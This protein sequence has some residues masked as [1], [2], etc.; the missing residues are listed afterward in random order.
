MKFGHG[1]VQVVLSLI[2]DLIGHE[3]SVDNSVCIVQNLEQRLGELGIQSL[4]DYFR[5]LDQNPKE[6]EKFISLS[7]VH[8]TSWFRDH[9]QLSSLEA[10]VVSE[11]QS[12]RKT[13]RVW[14]AACSTGQ[15]IYSFALILEDLKARGYNFEY[16]LMGSDIDRLSL[17]FASAA[18]YPIKQI[19]DIPKKYLSHLEQGDSVKGPIFRPAKKILDRA[20]FLQANLLGELSSLGDF[21]LVLLRNIL[22]YF[23][24]SNQKRVIRAVESRVSEK[25]LM[26]LG[27]SDLSDH[28]HFTLKSL[29]KAF[30]VREKKASRQVLV[31]DD[32]AM[33][34]VK[35]RGIF[36]TAGFGV[37]V[38]STTAE[39]E[40]KLRAQDFCAIT[41]DVNLGEENGLDWLAEK[42]KDEPLLV[43]KPVVIVSDLSKDQLDDEYDVIISETASYFEKSQLRT[44]SADLVSII[45]ELS[46]KSE[47]RPGKRSPQRAQS[48][49]AKKL[50]NTCSLILIGASTGG[51]KAVTELLESM[52]SN[53]PPIVIVQH[54][55][56]QFQESFRGRL[57]ARSG[58]AS[59]SQARERLLVPGHIYVPLTNEHIGVERKNG[60]WHMK[61]IIAPPVH[62][63]RP[64]VD[65]LFSSVT[66]AHE[67]VLGVLMTGMGKDGAQGLKWLHSNGSITFAQD[68]ASSVVW[69]M[70]GEA[71][72]IGA[73]D[74]MGSPQEIRSQILTLLGRPSQKIAG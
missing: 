50:Q 20:Q 17:Q 69:G 4:T 29:G 25:G 34:Q 18:E 39:A 56:W 41:L 55:D 31:I 23:D 32:S 47:G 62:R 67:E 9:D 74:F 64:A 26:C 72:R 73:A 21:D 14:S 70:P 42:R 12:G 45:D 51:P 60:Q 16:L 13:L 46:K 30:Y 65:V 8:T 15:E 1:E 27:A 52:P 40:E 59:G 66:D 54:L 48:I 3:F 58:L 6:L 2:R 11:I 35:L 38:A 36:A 28:S 57:C 19:E 68:E 63:C 44:K 7:T 22:F 43:Q 53:C 49:A 33:V 24:P 37:E 61:T 71:S 10:W 5:I